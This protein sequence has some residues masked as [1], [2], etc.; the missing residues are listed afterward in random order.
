[1]TCP[2]NPSRRTF[3]TRTSGALGSGWLAAQW[4]AFLAVAGVACSQR[5]A[6]TGYANISEAMGDALSAI[7]GQIIPSDPAAPGAH[8][9]GVI[10]FIDAWLGDRG[11]GMIPLLEDGIRQ[12]DAIAGGAGSFAAAEFAEQTRMLRKT[13]QEPFFSAVRFLTI[14]GMFAMPEH[15][16][17][18]D[19]SGWKLVGFQ[20]QHAWQP[21]FGHYDA[22]QSESEEGGV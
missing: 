3:L 21:P 6:Q 12:L 11:A 10:W 5:D 8:E 15:G 9:A 22:M 16:G 13:E 19:K 4:P 20:D 17:N 2:D 18:R 1:M 7:A 14:V